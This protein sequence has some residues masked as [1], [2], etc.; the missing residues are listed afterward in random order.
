MRRTG[1]DLSSTRCIL[2]DVEMPAT[3]HRTGERRGFRVHRYASLSS[4]E[5]SQALAAELTALMARK[6]FPQRAWI[7]LWDLHVVRDAPNV[8]QPSIATRIDTPAAPV[9]PRP[10][11]RRAQQPGAARRPAAVA[12]DS[13]EVEE[14]DPVVRS[15][16][17]SG[18]RRFALIDGRVASEGDAIGAGIVRAIEPDAVVIA[19]VDGK[20]RRIELPRPANRVANR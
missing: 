7:N 1:I 16:L 10:Q 19:T 8:S 18:D 6:E 20:I 15:I 14:P 4:A 12:R 9:P 17:V 3:E 11:A 13:A 5:S 2:A